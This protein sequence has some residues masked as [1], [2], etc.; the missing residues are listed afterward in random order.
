MGKMG[1]F[2]I[3]G[4]KELQKNLN[5]LQDP[6][7]FVEACARELA[8]RLLRMVVKRTPVGD[9]SKEIQVVA[10]R[11][12]KNHKKGDTYQK[13]VN[14][15]GKK[16]GTL[17][18]GWT[19]GQRVETYAAYVPIHHFGNTYVI[20]IVNPIEYASYVEYGHR[21]EPGR[22]VPAIG[23]K[24]KHGWVRGHFMMT[25]SEQELEKIAPK[26]LENKIK[27]Y[28]GGCLK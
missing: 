5:K 2:N 9:Y 20:E 4:L 6:D 8:A 11:D 24:L 16:G 10:K 14:P 28:L 12:S 7:K 19:D 22:Y 15:S 3:S 21:Q 26:V 17:R 25:I 18:R 23:K 27:K 13:K 1:S